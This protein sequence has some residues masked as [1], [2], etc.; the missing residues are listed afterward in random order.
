MRKSHQERQYFFGVDL[1]W[2]NRNATGLAALQWHGEIATFV[3]PLPEALA[4]TDQDIADYIGKVAL[5]GGVVVAIDAPLTVPHATG[6][7]P[8]EAELNAVFARFLA[9]AHSVNRQRLGT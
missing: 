9:E 3:E 7:R 5:Q 4:Y 1:A 6:R 8:G 2:S